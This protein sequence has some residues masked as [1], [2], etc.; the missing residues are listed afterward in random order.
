[1]LKQI[2]II[3]MSLAMASAAF[4]QSATGGVTTS[5]DPAKIAAIERHAA[6][7]KARPAAEAQ[8]KPVA[9]KS[10]STKTKTQATKSKPKSKTSSATKAK[11]SGKTSGATSKT[12][13]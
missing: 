6:E 1:V 5:T 11:T 7:L 8:A 13:K 12:G 3:V 10:A 9:K 2:P 4:G